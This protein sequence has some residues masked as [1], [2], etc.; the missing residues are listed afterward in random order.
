[1]LKLADG[2]SINISGA[3]TGN[4]IEHN[5]LYDLMYTGFRTDDW[6]DETYIRN[7]I[8]WNCGGSAYIFKGHNYLENNIAVNAS[9][10]VHLRAFPQQTFKEGAVIRNNIFTSGSREFIVYK[11]TGWP[12]HMNLHRP[13]RDLM[14]YEYEVDY[15]VYW[16]PGAEEFLEEQKSNGIEEH[17]VAA[18]P[19]FK[20]PETGDF[21]LKKDSP[22]LKLGFKEIDSRP[23]SFGITSAYP[24]KFLELDRLYMAGTGPTGV[25]EK[26][27]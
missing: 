1:M 22:A 9:K 5:L 13:G 2:S 7:N 16:Y 18:D 3:G 27:H 15:N 21:S 24:E 17:T 6:Q 26:Q 11:P 23:E 20:N 25:A 4:I 12:R 14:P 19:L 10:A 8:V